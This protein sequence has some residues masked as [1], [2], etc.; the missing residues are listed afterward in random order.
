MA[1]KAVTGVSLKEDAQEKCVLTIRCREVDKSGA[2]R[3]NGE[4]GFRE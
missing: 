1:L 2:A 4:T 3:P